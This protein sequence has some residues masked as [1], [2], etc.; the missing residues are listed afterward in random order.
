MVGLVAVPQQTPFA[1]TAAPPSA[2]TLPPDVA[3]LTVISVTVAV[4]N[5]GGSGFF[6]HALSN[7]IPQIKPTVNNTL[8]DLFII[9]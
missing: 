2:V 4:V 7:A 1:V 9:N 6:L 5:V 8:K 3:V